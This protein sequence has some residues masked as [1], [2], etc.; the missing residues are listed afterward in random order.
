M[1]PA[2]FYDQLAPRYHEIY[3]DWR[4]SMA[5][6]A[7]QLD[8]IIGTHAERPRQT[9]LDASCGI[10]TQALGLAQLGYEV[11]GSDISPASVARVV[12]EAKKC[13][14]KAHFEVA[15]MRKLWAAHKRQ[16]DVVLSCDNSVPHLTSD[17]QILTAFRQM[18]KC[19]RPGG[20]CLITVRDYD[21][22]DKTE[23]QVKPYGVVGDRGKQT[24]LFQVWHFRGD[25]YTVA[26]YR[27]EEIR[28]RAPKISVL[29]TEYYA[30][31]TSVLMK[32]MQDA[33]FGGVKRLDNVFYQPVLI[34]RR[35]G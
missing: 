16:F 29:R 1:K 22:E 24:V 12:R 2:D 31:S 9:L 27:I 13:R 5:R 14:V 30:V 17:K 6:Q 7:G 34:G 35:P 11:T 15:D 19:T 20:L 26:L 10:G 18:H 8:Q 33:G 21:A 3:A 25:K 32:L 4:R 23:V 28:G